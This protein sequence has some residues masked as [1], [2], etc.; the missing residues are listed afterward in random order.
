MSS[1]PVDRRF[2][3]ALE[4][5]RADWAAADPA[6]RAAQAG[7]EVVA[8]GVQVPFFGRP[9]LVGHPSGDVEELAPSAAAEPVGAADQ[10]V[11]AE[12]AHP[13]VAILLMHY[14]L[15]ADGAPPAG[16]WLAYRELPGGLFYAT[17]FARRAE[18][19]L[20][21]A[22][23]G[24]AGPSGPGPSAFAAAAAGLGGEPLALADA[25]FRF[26]ALPRLAVAALLTFADDESPGS[27]AVLFDAAAAHYLPPE[28]LAGLGGYLAQRLTR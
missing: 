21:R 22:F 11:A 28:D 1:E 16:E 20:A 4:R 13:A 27:A 8:G 9:H 15:T 2:A 19:P 23:A 5:A 10:A 25:A 12:P 7:C 17:A 24:P 18:E 26:Q 6:A 14:L 3:D